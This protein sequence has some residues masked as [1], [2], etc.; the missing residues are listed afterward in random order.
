MRNSSRSAQTREGTVQDASAIQA[1]SH[2]LARDAGKLPS[3]VASYAFRLAD[4]LIVAPAF[5][6]SVAV[7]CKLGFI[8]PQSF[9]RK[10]RTQLWLLLSAEAMP[11]CASYAGRSFSSS[12]GPSS[13]DGSRPEHTKH[14]RNAPLKAGA[15]WSRKLEPG[16]RSPNS[17]PRQP[18]FP[19]FCGAV[20]FSR[21]LIRECE[22]GGRLWRRRPTA[23]AL[24]LTLAGGLDK[25]GL[26][27]GGA[28]HDTAPDTKSK[29]TAPHP[30][31]NSQNR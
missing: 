26:R 31:Q 27:T 19:N 5:V 10:R 22:C 23:V 29:K 20:S 24:V 15:N 14:S 9:L 16:L 12:L 8:E 3:G 18:T 11:E 17:S 1:T 6:A 25:V 13:L 28:A 7:L 21:S 30:S 2:S 4:V